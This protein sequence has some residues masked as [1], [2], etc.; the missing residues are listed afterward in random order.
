MI[1]KLAAA[2]IPVLGTPSSEPGPQLRVM[3]AAL[4]CHLRDCVHAAHARCAIARAVAGHRVT[5]AA[6][7]QRLPLCGSCRLHSPAG[8]NVRHA[9]TF[10]DCATAWHTAAEWPAMHGPRRRPRPRGHVSRYRGWV[11]F[12]THTHT[13][14][15]IIHRRPCQAAAWLWRCS[16][17]ICQHSEL[18]VSHI[19]S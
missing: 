14:G 6:L 10:R 19:H 13:Q 1:A 12:K 7:P 18:L 2:V 16:R 17:T 11:K 9:L 5:T 3:S 15:S 8:Y 4:G